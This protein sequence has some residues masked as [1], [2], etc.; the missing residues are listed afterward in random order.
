MEGEG[1]RE[2]EWGKERSEGEGV[3]EGEEGG[4]GRRRSGG[5]EGQTEEVRGSVEGWRSGKIGVCE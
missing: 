3:G 2:K 5:R 1:V 4:G